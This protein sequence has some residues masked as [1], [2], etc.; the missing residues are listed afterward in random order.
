MDDGPIFSHSK[1]HF[2]DD[3]PIFTDIFP[4][5]HEK[6]LGFPQPAEPKT[7]GSS[8]GPSGRGPEEPPRGATQSGR[9]CE[10]QLLNPGIC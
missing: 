6:H 9:H 2:I 8:K 7:L 5:K 4:S 1:R 10:G 3:G